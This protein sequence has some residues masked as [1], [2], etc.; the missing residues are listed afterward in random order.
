MQ[1][2]PYFRSKIINKYIFVFMDIYTR[3]HNTLY[4][5]K[6]ILRFIYVHNHSVVGNLLNNQM[7]VSF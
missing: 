2:S 3:V 5:S 6:T 4:I 1:T 7:Y